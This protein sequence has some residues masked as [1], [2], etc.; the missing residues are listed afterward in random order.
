MP[1]RIHAMPRT[2]PPEARACMRR[3]FP[4]PGG[5][6]RVALA[7]RGNISTVLFVNC[8]VLVATILALAAML[9]ALSA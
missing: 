9:G 3:N 7:R 1:Y 6:I 2:D 4:R 8:T 5:E